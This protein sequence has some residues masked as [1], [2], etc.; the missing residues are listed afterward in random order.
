MKLGP[1]LE[2]TNVKSIEMP[3]PRILEASQLLKIRLLRLE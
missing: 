1:S 2:R 3:T